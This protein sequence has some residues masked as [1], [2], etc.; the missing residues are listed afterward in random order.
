ML[1][2]NLT[3]MELRR[4]DGPS[5]TRSLYA[6]LSHTWGTPDDEPEVLYKD[7]DSDDLKD[8]I[9]AAVRQSTSQETWDRKKKGRKLLG[10]CRKAKNF[11]LSWG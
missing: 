9:A 7:W 4:F 1:L 8:E 6:I 2:L 11:G 10:F 3:T 5:D